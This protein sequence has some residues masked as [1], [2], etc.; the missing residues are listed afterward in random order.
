[1]NGV[2]LDVGSHSLT[3]HRAP[4]AD[5]DELALAVEYM[6]LEL[7]DERL[8]ELFKRFNRSGGEEIK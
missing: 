4:C 6:G 2:T 1:M 8:A 7:S 3:V 5:I